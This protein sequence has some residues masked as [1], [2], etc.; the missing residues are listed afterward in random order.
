MRKD[1]TCSIRGKKLS[2]LSL[3]HQLLLRKMKKWLVL[4]W[5]YLCR[6][7]LNNLNSLLKKHLFC[8]SR[9]RS[10]SKLTSRVFRL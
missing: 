2:I 9:M 8:Q 6:K 5:P 1:Y 4:V 10:K 7:S 3:T